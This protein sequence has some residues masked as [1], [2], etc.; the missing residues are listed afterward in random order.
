MMTLNECFQRCNSKLRS[1]HKNYVK[2]FH[3]F[4]WNRKGAAISSI[5]TQK[6]NLYNGKSESPDA[7]SKVI[8]E[9]KFL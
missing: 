7:G 4:F 2:A 3:L 5:K 8:L 1:T 6:I 9:I